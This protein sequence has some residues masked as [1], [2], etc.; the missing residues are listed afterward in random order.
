MGT[1]HPFV[2]KKILEV[3]FQVSDVQRTLLNLVIVYTAIHIGYAIFKN[4][5]NVKINKLIAT[6]LQDIRESLF[7]KVLKFK[8]KT[9]EKYNSAHLYTRLTDDVEQL[10]TLFLGA[11]NVVLNN[12]VYLIF[13]V[14]MMF[15]ANISLAWIGFATI[16]AIGMSTKKFTKVL[17]NLTQ[18]FMNKRDEE[19]KRFSEFFNRNKLTYLYQ[20]QEK[21]IKEANTLFEEELQFRKSYIFTQSFTYWA[22]TL[23]EA[24]GI[25]AVLYYALNIEVSISIGSIYLILFYIKECRGPLNEICNQLEEIQNCM[26]SYRRIQE[27]LQEKNL[28]DLTVGEKVDTVKGDIEFQ[29]VCMK[30][31]KETILQNISFIIKEGSKVTIAG[32]TGAGKTTLVNVLMKLY[33]IQSGKIL[34]GNKD[35]HKISTKSLRE[36][37]SYIFT[38]TVR[39]NIRLGKEEITDEQIKSLAKEIGADALFEKLPEGLDTKIKA[40]EMSYGELQMIAFIRAILHQA[41]IYI[42]DEPTS[43]IDLKTEKMIQEIIDHISKTSTVII[44]AHRKSTI[45]SSDKVIYLK[46]GRVDMIVNK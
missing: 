29:N 37:I 44:I 42:F 25:Y 19:N 14:I 6:I 26:V 43:N 9:F 41:N 11:L 12:I 3:D 46:D 7:D 32:R 13:M 38:D 8:M 18:K 1:I 39:N 15:F 34:I 28:E 23:L 40:N 17:G 4:V 27:V 36:N 24:V 16:C 22:L 33:D 10:S 31:E 35:I 20:L 5:R 2:M 45:A 21:N 30:Y